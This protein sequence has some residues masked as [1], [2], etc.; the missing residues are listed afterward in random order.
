MLRAKPMN[1]SLSDV[2]GR[3]MKKL[4]EVAV[5]FL[6]ELC[7]NLMTFMKNSTKGIAF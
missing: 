6:L 5:F 3:Q 7:Q 4:A 2:R 1:A